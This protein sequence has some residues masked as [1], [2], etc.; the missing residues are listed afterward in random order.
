MNHMEVYNDTEVE[1]RHKDVG[2]SK[3]FERA[4]TALT[5][6]DKVVLDTGC[7][8]G[9]YLTFF[10]RGSVGLTTTLHEVE[11]GQKEGIDIR[12]GNVEKLDELSFPQLFDAVWANNIFEHLLSPHAFLI[13]LKPIV[14]KDGE[15]ILGVPMVPMVPS[16]MQIKKFRGA[17]ASN[18][19]NF[20]SIHTLRLT[21]ERAGWKV[22]EMRPFIFSNKFLDIL[23]SPFAPHIY[24]VA[25]NDGEFRYPP[26]KL[27]E[28]ESDTHYER[29]L[30]IAGKI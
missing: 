28:W 23:V 30:K 21:I 1:G 24:A 4:R 27:K 20:F 22:K 26:K 19:I 10:G 11:Y 3:T 9:E 7:G 12:Q 13:T 6:K 16:L 8:Y 15:V 17:L 14:K 18:H 2:R 5:L 29:L 25:T